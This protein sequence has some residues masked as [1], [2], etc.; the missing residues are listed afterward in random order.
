MEFRTAKKGEGCM[1]AGYSTLPLAKACYFFLRL[2]AF[3]YSS[4]LAVR[5][6]WLISE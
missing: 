1:T 2:P 4:E 3:E 6:V 5:P